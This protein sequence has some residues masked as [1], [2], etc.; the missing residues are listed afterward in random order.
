M[1]AM[2]RI[3]R[4]QL[5]KIYAQAAEEHPAECCGL[6]TVGPTG[7]ASRAHPC[8][9]IQDRLHTE[10]PQEY[11]R[12]A[13]IAYFID[14]KQLLT[15]I[16]EAERAGGAVSGFYHSHI[17]CDAYFSDEDKERALTWDEPAYPDAIHLVVSVFEDGVKGH[18]AF[19]WN[20][21]VAVFE[22]VQVE[23]TDGE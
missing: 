16:T 8:V 15:I 11:P 4:A 22:E 13:R 20:A 17:D 1:N 6:L 10:N 14:P 23:I 18:K 2:V 9:N 7:G 19:G 21:K 5:E 12:E 3:P